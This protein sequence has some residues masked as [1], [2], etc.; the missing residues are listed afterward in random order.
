MDIT[1]STVQAQFPVTIFTI[2]GFLNLGTS[3]HLE[4]KAREVFNSGSR[5]LLLD[6]TNVTSLS[7][8]GLRAIL[9]IYKL[10]ESETETIE[11]EKRKDTTRMHIG[12]SIHLKLVNPRPEIRRILSISGFEKFIEIFENTDQALNS[13]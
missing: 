10:F 8:A 5:Y 11:T 2:N 13:I 9:F 6:L 1:I 12:K 3:S 4:D 7:S